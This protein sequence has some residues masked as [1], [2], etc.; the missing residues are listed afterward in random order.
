MGFFEGVGDI[1]AG[2]AQLLG[3]NILIKGMY[4]VN[5]VTDAALT[6]FT[7]GDNVL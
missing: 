6:V 1:L 2:G 5:T 3:T 4:T 7:A